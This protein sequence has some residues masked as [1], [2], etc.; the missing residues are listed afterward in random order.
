MQK[1]I[2][3]I[4]H[5]FVLIFDGNIIHFYC[6]LKKNIYLHFTIKFCQNLK[7]TFMFIK[8]KLAEIHGTGKSDQSQTVVFQSCHIFIWQ[9]SQP[10]LFSSRR[11]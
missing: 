9:Q 10:F 5:I 7:N 11:I 6:N 3:A 8:R 2:F 1:R 4:G